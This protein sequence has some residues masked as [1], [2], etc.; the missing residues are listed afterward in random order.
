MMQAD[1]KRRRA[2]TVFV[3][4]SFVAVAV[5]SPLTWSAILV[6]AHKTG[7]PGLIGDLYP[8]TVNGSAFA[9]AMVMWDDVRTGRRFRWLT[10]CLL[11]G[12]LGMAAVMYIARNVVLGGGIYAAGAVAAIPGVVLAMLL[13]LLLTGSRRM[14]PPARSES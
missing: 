5:I 11:V 12:G 7:N 4:V 3:I 1:D 14:A 9:A 13:V 8:F 6:E 10:C 2:A